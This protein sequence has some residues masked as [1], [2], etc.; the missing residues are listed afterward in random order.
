MFNHGGGFRSV[1][2]LKL[3]IIMAK[4]LFVKEINNTISGMFKNA[5]IYY[6]NA[7]DRQYEFFNTDAPFIRVGDR[8]GWQDFKSWD[9]A[10]DYANS[11]SGEFYVGVRPYRNK[12]AVIMAT[13]KN[14]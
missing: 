10:A 4:K 2:L 3:F 9:E 1:P 6:K 8:Q 12:K 11:R 14:V 13:I 5:D 7:T